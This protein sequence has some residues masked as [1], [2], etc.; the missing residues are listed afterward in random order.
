[1]P[2]CTHP[3]PSPRR[4]LNLPK[5]LTRE[6]RASKTFTL[7]VVC[8]AIFTDV[9]VYGLIIPV[10]PFAL[11]SRLGVPEENVQMW[12]SVLL[13]ILGAALLVGS[14]KYHL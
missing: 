9:F 1:M 10:M 3:N 7:I 13:G 8:V 2:E 6:V 4:T 12:N 5:M 14:R 11:T